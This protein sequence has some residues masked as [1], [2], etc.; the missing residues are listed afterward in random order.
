MFFSEQPQTNIHLSRPWLASTYITYIHIKRGN[1]KPE[2]TLLWGPWDHW[3]INYYVSMQLISASW[4]H[5]QD[6]K[7][8][9][10]RKNN[11]EL[12]PNSS[13]LWC[14]FKNLW[15]VCKKQVLKVW[16]SVDSMRPGDTYM[17]Q[18]TKQHW[19]KQWI[20]GWAV[21]SHY[22]NQWWKSVRWALRNKL[23]WNLNRNSYIFI[24]ENK[25]ENVVR[26]KWRPF[27]L[28]FNVIILVNA[29]TD[30]CPWHHSGANTE[31]TSFKS[32][33]MHRNFDYAH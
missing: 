31:W 32:F 23:Q 26:K 33:P 2:K 17:R 16:A 5:L 20:V 22:M 4:P 29:I 27:C 10:S 21:P 19:F 14:I 6:Y 25:F 1:S 11:M 9:I 15:L 8:Y 7:R 28:G 13:S 12:I 3:R 30:H 18:E 24:Q